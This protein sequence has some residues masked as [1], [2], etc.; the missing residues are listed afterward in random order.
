MFKRRAGQILL[1][2]GFTALII[3]AWSGAQYRTATALRLFF[4]APFGLATSSD[5]LIYVGVDGRDVHAY[6]ASGRPVGAWTV[7]HDA[8]RFRLRARQDG[9]IE[10]ARE[11]PAE[12]VVYNVQGEVIERVPEPGVFERFGPDQDHR[13][14][15]GDNLVFEITDE[16]LVRTQDGERVLVVTHSGWLSSGMRAVLGMPYNVVKGSGLALPNTAINL[17][18]WEGAGWQVQLWGERGEFGERQVRRV[19]ELSELGF[20]FAMGAAFALFVRRALA[21][22]I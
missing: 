20:A 12:R 13:L 2:L 9:L 17:L 3:G 16:G 22:V 19:G 1:V 4:V 7:A 6:E 5:G 8:G 15:L 14:A 11:I 18:R 21:L 10:V